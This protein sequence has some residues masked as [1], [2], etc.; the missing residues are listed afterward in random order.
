[1]APFLFGITTDVGGS[2]RKI[3]PRIPSSGDSV[4]EPRIEYKFED[5]FYGAK[6]TYYYF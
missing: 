5:T 3:G 4:V 1:M 2:D 6:N